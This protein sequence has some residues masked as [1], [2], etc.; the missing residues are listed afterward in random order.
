M[1]GPK[2]PE[3]SLYVDLRVRKCPR[4]IHRKLVRYRSILD[5]QRGGSP[6]LD[7]AIID[8]LEKATR[9]VKLIEHNEAHS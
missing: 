2:I 4:I 6:N 7:D 9:K 8:L 5:V 1:K 3:N